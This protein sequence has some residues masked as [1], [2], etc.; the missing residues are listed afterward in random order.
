MNV[1]RRSNDTWCMREGL[2]KIYIVNIFCNLAILYKKIEIQ[3]ITTFL[4][5]LQI[6]TDVRIPSP[7]KSVDYNKQNS[8]LSESIS[9]IKYHR[10][11]C[12]AWLQNILK[13][14]MFQDCV[15]VD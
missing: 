6:L 3:S 13:Y 12:L 11:K 7:K 8:F 10:L 14:I 4:K 1:G 5:M 15:A 2:K 9:E